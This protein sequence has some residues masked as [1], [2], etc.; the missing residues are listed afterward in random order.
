MNFG[1]FCELSFEC[2]KYFLQALLSI[3]NDDYWFASSGICSMA[4][5][6]RGRESAGEFPFYMENHS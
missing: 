5:K 3:L 6:L 1:I 4:A 2:G